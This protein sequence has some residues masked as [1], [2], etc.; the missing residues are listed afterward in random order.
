MK[1]VL[2]LFWQLNIEISLL[3]T[4][5]LAARYIVRKTTKVYNAYLLWLS[6]PLGLLVASG[7]SKL[8]FAAEPVAPVSSAII[9]YVVVPTSTTDNWVLLGYAWLTITALLL[10]RLARQHYSL[11]KDLRAVTVNVGL[12]LQ[13]QFPIVA[14][15]KA[16]FSPAV[17]GFITPRIYF[18]VHL[19]EELST[20]QVELI[21]EHEQHHIKQQ[22]LWL[23]LIWDVLVCVLWFNPLAYL[24]RQ[25]FRHDQELYCDYLVLYKSNKQSK[26][27]Y[28]HALLSTVSAT[29]SVS[30]LC[31]WKSFNQLEERIMNIKKPSSLASKSMLLMFGAAI[32]ACTSLYAV[33]AEKIVKHKKV[34]K[35]H[36]G[37]G[38]QKSIIKINKDGKTF[39][40][41]DGKRYVVEGEQK[42]ELTAAEAEQFDLE[43]SQVE[44]N[45]MSKHHGMASVGG[46][47][48]KQIKIIRTGDGTG[49]ISDEEWVE[50][51]ESI[52]EAE[53]D[54]EKHHDEFAMVQHELEAAQKEIEA[55]HEAD[56]ISAKAMRK[57]QKQIASTQKRIEKDK[58]K[59]QQAL[60]QARADVEQL[61]TE[62]KSSE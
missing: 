6:I 36:K 54:I 56:K 60:E 28:G 27:S 9:N 32:I 2:N 25:G 4:V 51:H 11:R 59:M 47:E 29:H 19:L 1:E 8:E 43:V 42:R 5:I 7:V 55:A 23:N 61:R 12:G 24:S 16:D 33:S 17:Y 30:L 39:V 37:D 26:Q 48:H 15:E 18:P 10:L 45:I 50:I 52:R 21:I 13:S 31:S 46:A 20:Q 41:E 22:H 14:I 35:M 38:T 3:L 62:L 34:I 44:K 57:A 58:V 53:M 49:D 40:D